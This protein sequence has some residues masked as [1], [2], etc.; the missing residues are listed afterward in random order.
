MTSR[1]LLFSLA[2]LPALSRHAS[3]HSEDKQPPRKAICILDPQPNQTA[4]GIVEF[5]QEA[6]SARST[7]KGRFS[8]LNPSSEHGI[9]IHQYGNL[10]D[11]CTTAGAHY[12]PHN[13][14]HGGPYTEERHI[15]DLGNI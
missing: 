10:I 7:I 5:E 8:N 15:G 6:Y 1:I 13:K 4:K 9:H 3:N 11:G 12:N 14:N 2:S